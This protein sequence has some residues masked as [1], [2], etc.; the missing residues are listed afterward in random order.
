[1]SA[2]DTSFL[3]LTRRAAQWYWDFVI[4]LWVRLEEALTQPC[5]CL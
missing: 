3:A 4:Q 1:M 5:L 2:A